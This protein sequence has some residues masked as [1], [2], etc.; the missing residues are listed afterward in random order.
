[1]AEVTLGYTDEQ[2]KNRVRTAM[3]GRVEKAV[4]RHV[5]A[6]IDSLLGTE[7]D[8]EV[9]RAKWKLRGTMKRV[10][11]TAATS[12]RGPPQSPSVPVGSSVFAFP[13]ISSRI[14]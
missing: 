7:E 1:M 5:D 13:R 3:R 11:E 14:G 9:K 12:A 6:I 10:M 2:L 8:V 4:G